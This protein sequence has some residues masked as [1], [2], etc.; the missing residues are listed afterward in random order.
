M[1]SIDHNKRHRAWW[2]AARPIARLLTSALFGFEGE[3]CA[4]KGPLFVLC[5]HNCDLDPAFL[6]ASFREQGYF[7]TSEHV[8]RQGLLSRFIVFI[9]D[10]IGR[11]KAGS[12][13]GTVKDMLRRLKKGYSVCLFPEGNRSFD[14][15]TRP[16]PPSTG[17][18]ARVCGAT[19]VTYR[20]EGSYLSNP[21]W[22][23][24]LRRGRVL[25]RVAGIYPPEALRA[26]TDD[27]VNETIARDL[28]EDAFARQ[29]AEMIEFRG[30][31]LAEHL[32]TLLFVCPECGAVH[33]MQSSGDEFFCLSC[34]YKLRYQPTGFF[35]GEGVVFDNVRDW[36]V[37]QNEKISAMCESA[38]AG[39]IFSDSGMELCEVSSG[40]W[41]KKLS[42]GDMRLFRDRLELPGGYA[43]PISE[44]TGMSLRGQKDLFIGAGDRHYLLRTPYVRCT[45]KYLTACADLGCPVGYGV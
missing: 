35:T 39:E 19:L 32:E 9:N 41:M 45:V 22:G 31:R 27:E 14:G 24:T 13:A 10:P 5:N 3:E 42:R 36:N 23:E 20:T 34:G 15:V 11:M 33:R 1:D 26:M 37:W 18:V 44:I 4:L 2:A 6:V 38:G 29:R 25:G 21:R 40:R 8:L 43:L 7:V 17:K 30:R 16:F 28:Y 12:A